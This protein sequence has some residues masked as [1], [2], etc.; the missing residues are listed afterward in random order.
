MLAPQLKKGATIGWCSP[1]SKVS[2]EA[3]ERF[4]RGMKRMG[5]D[6]VLADNIFKLTDGYLPS[7]EERAADFNQMIHDDRV[8]L[9]FFSGGEAGP[10]LLPYID[11]D[12]LKKRPK[13][14]L[15]YSDSTTILNAIWSKTGLTTYYGFTPAL[16]EDLRQY[17]WEHF[18]MHLM[19]GPA[20]AHTANSL[21]HVQR[22]GVA[23]GILVGGYSRNVAM[24]MNGEYF[25]YDPN[26]KYLLFLEDHEKF[27]GP[28]Y[29]S[30]MI[31]HIEQCDF[32]NH[33]TGLVFGH[34]S[35]TL[36]EHLLARLSRF[37]EKHHVPVVYCDDFGH[38]VN[39]AILPIGRRAT[40]N[41]A[42]RSLIYE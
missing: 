3:A 18:V 38:G 27:G 11:Y 1:S 19:E 10:E 32:I 40:L 23:S 36:N 31:S 17:N 42:D 14:V 25:K 2:P 26:E 33:V 12:A 39:H 8:D 28:A 9:I 35:T 34:Y 13:A 15:S 29:V 41:T 24:L 37:G 16:F 5:F 7:I 30:A 21:W 20:K 22:E 6:V 4:I